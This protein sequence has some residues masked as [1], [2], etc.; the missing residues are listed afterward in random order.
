MEIMISWFWLVK[1]VF[2]LVTI[3][4]CYKA[5]FKHKFGSKFWNI[6]AL[7]LVL[8]AI[9]QPFKLNSTAVTNLYKAQQNRVI[10]QAKVLPEKIEDSSFKDAQKN[11]GITKQQ[12]WEK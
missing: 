1:L 12:I 5:F 2:A 6:T 3:F 10:E 7:V 8:L 9:Y 4:V 11:L